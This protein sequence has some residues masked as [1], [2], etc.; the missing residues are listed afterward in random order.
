MQV[1]A[2]TKM[3]YAGAKATLSQTVDVTGAYLKQL[4]KPVGEKAKE[5]K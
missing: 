5:L 4:F 3:K 1:S 2:E